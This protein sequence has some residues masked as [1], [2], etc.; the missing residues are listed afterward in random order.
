M[1][2]KVNIAFV[3]IQYVTQSNSWG[4]KKITKRVLFH[5]PASVTSVPHLSPETTFNLMNSYLSV[6]FQ[7]PFR[8]N[9]LS[10]CVCFF[11]DLCIMKSPTIS[12]PEPADC[13]VRRRFCNY[14]VK[15]ASN[16]SNLCV[17]INAWPAYRAICYAV[18]VCVCLC[19]D[20]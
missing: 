1:F 6:W 7:E 4:K 11:I 13:Q 3:Q 19:S 14:H 16:T 2:A 17:D 5:I 9:D 8:L 20:R 12:T 15:H 18:C 10:M